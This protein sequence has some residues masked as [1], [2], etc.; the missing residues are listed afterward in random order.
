MGAVSVVLEGSNALTA[1]EKAAGIQKNGTADGTLT[2]SG[3]GTLTAQGGEYGAGIGG[4]YCG[5]G[6]NITITGGIIT[7]TGGSY[8]A[9]IGGG[10]WGGGSNITIN[11]GEVTATG[12]DFGAG[13]GG[14][15]YENGRNITISG[16]TVTATG[17]LCGAGIGG[18]EGRTGSD[19]TV[20]GGTI[21]TTGG[22]NATDIGGGS[23]GSTGTVTITGGSVK[24][25]KGV[26]TGVTNG[27]GAVYCTV[28]DLTDEFG[29]EAAVTDVGE[30]AYGMKDVM[31]DADGKIYMYLPADETSIVFGTHF[32]SG[33]V[34]A[35]AGADN[36]LTRGTECKYSLLVL[37]APAYY[38]RN[39]S[40]Q[41]ILI[42]DGAN[43]TIKSG[44]GYG[45]NNYSPM[46]IQIEENAS[47]TLTLDGAYMDASAI[48][49][50][51]SPILIP[52]TV[53]EM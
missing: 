2:I 41:G 28:V 37:G 20:S 30:T 26:L 46:R 53:P 32:Y 15:R 3:S 4:G 18:G 7:A 42:K 35:E 13:I 33:T 50:I 48:P 23:G 16:G 6:S 5:V 43:L 1:G 38:E 52:E 51:S 25:T 44:N 40:T 8:G 11:G 12:G 10:F 27:T 34:S 49:Y 29:I 36:R 31:T 24:T 19:I 14:G 47:V 39:E 45:K 9:G 17:G 21:T 22:E